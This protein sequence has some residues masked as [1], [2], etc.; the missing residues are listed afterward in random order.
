VAK[1]VEMAALHIA[2]GDV[3]ARLAQMYVFSLPVMAILMLASL[4]DIALVCEMKGDLKSAET[5]A[6]GVVQ[7]MRMQLSLQKA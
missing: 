5:S 2:E 3:T 1:L 4:L 7:R 6:I